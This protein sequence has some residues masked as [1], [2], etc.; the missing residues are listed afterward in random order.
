VIELALHS[1]YW[2]IQGSSDEA[3]LVPRGAPVRT[4]AIAGTCPPGVDC[5]SVG[6]RFTARQAGTA[7]ISAARTLCGEALRCRPEQSTFS[8]TVIVQ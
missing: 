7:R 6:L 3:V 5:G 1:T 4:P 8:L 2:E